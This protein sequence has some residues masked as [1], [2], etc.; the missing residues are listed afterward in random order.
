MKILAS[1]FIR[2]HFSF[3]ILLLGGGGL[4]LSNVAL[5]F[6]LTP[7][8]YAKYGLLSAFVAIVTVFS[9]FGFDQIILRYAKVSKDCVEIPTETIY[10]SMILIMVS[11]L[12]LSV[13]FGAFF[14]G[15][16]IWMLFVFSVTSAIVIY[17]YTLFRIS[18]LFIAAQI[19]KNA[20][21]ILFPIVLG[22]SLLYFNLDSNY[23][24]LS[25]TILMCLTS[26][27]G[28]FQ[29]KNVN[30]KFFRQGFYDWNLLWGYFS[31]MMIMSFMTSG[32]R[33]FIDGV[34]G[35][36]ELARYFFLQNIFLFPLSQLQNYF[37]FKDV[38]VFKERLNIKLLNEKL[39]KNVVVSLLASSFILFLFMIVLFVFPV[40]NYFNISR[41][42]ALIGFLIITGLVRVWYASLSAAMSIFADSKMINQSNLLSC[43]FLLLGGGVLLNVEYQSVFPIVIVFFAFWLQRSVIYYYVLRRGLREV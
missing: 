31:A 6:F 27:L 20:W 13:I 11:S 30:K 24:L 37:G 7:D 40:N 33:F 18:S 1:K 21:K 14:W 2:Q 26:V 9:G 43:V 32:D 19:Q 38:V 23:I 36:E 12:I 8:E 15:Q 35:K 5:S 28:W 42:W 16:H 4:Y 41:D 25:I 34:L 17:Y 29:S 10:P 3:F 39:L 22:V